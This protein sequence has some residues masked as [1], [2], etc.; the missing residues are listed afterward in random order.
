MEHAL[1]ER[2]NELARKSRSEGLTAE[3]KAEQQALRSQ[4]LKEFRQGMEAMLE[5][6]RLQRPDGTIQP[7]QK[8]ET[9]ENKQ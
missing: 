3:E 7:L 6:V 8:K 2:I 4:Y 5:G 9:K 1:I